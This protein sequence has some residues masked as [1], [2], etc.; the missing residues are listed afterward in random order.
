MAI[1]FNT[2]SKRKVI[3]TEGQENS[4]QMQMP[5]MGN[6]DWIQMETL[7][8]MQSVGNMIMSAE[9]STLPIEVKENMLNDF[10]YY[11]TIASVI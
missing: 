3:E 6:T 2:P 4:P 1:G 10:A 8:R 11:K 5:E 7:E 9:F